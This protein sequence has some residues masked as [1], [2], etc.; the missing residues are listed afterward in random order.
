MGPDLCLTPS[1]LQFMTAK[2]L[3]AVVQQMLAPPSVRELRGLEA[4]DQGTVKGRGLSL[5]VETPL[6]DKRATKAVRSFLR[7]KRRGARAPHR[8][9]TREKPGEGR[10]QDAT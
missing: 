2:D 10:L 8:R 9:F 7:K 5:R 4:P 3:Q 1:T 6:G